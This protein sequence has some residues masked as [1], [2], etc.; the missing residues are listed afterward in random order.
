MAVD[1]PIGSNGLGLSQKPNGMVNT[2]LATA[3][4]TEMMPLYRPTKVQSFL[5]NLKEADS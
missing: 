5:L 4:L 3:K 1:S 2:P